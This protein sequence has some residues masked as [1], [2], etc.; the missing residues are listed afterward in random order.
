[1]NLEIEKKWLVKSD[2][3]IM[4]PYSVDQLEELLLRRQVA[5]IDEVRDTEQRWLYIREVPQLKQLVETV[6]HELS[7]R[8]E[9]TQTVQINESSDTSTLAKT[10]TK[11]TELQQVEF[12]A[13]KPA[14]TDVSVEAEDVAYSDID[15]KFPEMQLVA[16]KKKLLPQFVSTVDP[17][18]KIEVKS[19]KKQ[20]ILSG[21]AVVILSVA[22]FFGMYYYKKNE[23]LKTEQSQ[24][25]KLRKLVIYGADQKA[26][27]AYQKLSENLQ[28]KVL[29]DILVLF[30]KLD[31]DGA[32]NLEDALQSIQSKNLS[33]NQKS[34]IE[35]IQFNKKLS[36]N[37]LNEAK[38]HLVKAKDFDPSSE[39]V[40]ESEAIF[41]YYDNKNLESA[42]V[43]L[44][45]FSTSNK[46]RHLFGVALNHLT[47]PMMS[48]SDMIEKIERYL[49][50]R[51]EFKK[52]L[53]FIQIYLTLKSTN[54]PASSQFVADFVNS[55]VQLTQQFKLPSLVYGPFYKF[56][57]LMPFYEKVK[58]Q[59]SAKNNGLLEL[60]FSLEKNDAYS[61][62]KTLDQI[63]GQLTSTEKHN[64]Q[65][66]IFSLLNRFQEAL[67]VEK[68][69][70]NE[71]LSTASHYI[72]LKLKKE[73]NAG[74]IK[75]Q[76]EFLKKEKN[77]LSLWTDLEQMSSS[78][79][80]KIRSF[81][82]LN[83]GQIDDFIPFIDARAQFE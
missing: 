75:N 50:T 81:I 12:T 8:T 24:I 80:E 2:S 54:L 53:C 38:I 18:V 48:D 65:I 31:Q 11:T 59:L 13:A 41:N 36:I 7:L 68:I 82:Q 21:L 83:L 6:R 23:Q 39:L 20:Y 72:I 42:K 71:T 64:A 52:E 67:A 5:L 37:N 61:A 49:A 15:M 28:N 9:N 40:T 27:E 66:I 22:A 33:A 62:Q 57:K 51:V 55:P 19:Y 74:D 35:L 16:E 34:I 10:Q 78:E 26:S 14:F 56:E 46:G 29:S 47:K 73:H 1:M 60:Y 4:G 70:V 44:N 17:N 77:I 76:I 79:P 32:I 43:F 30:P 69:A 45:L 3:K 63:Q 25:T 58:S